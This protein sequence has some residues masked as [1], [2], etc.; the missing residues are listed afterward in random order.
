MKGVQSIAN[1]FIFIL[2]SPKDY[3]TKIKRSCCQLTQISLHTIYNP[4]LNSWH[5]GIYIMYR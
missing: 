2:P 1:S 5:C 4:L 3:K